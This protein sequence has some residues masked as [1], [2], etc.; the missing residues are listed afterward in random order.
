M[1][2]LRGH[3]TGADCSERFCPKGTAWADAAISEDTAHQEAECSGRGICDRSSGSCSCDAGFGGNACQ[4]MECPGNCFGQGKCSTMHELASTGRRASDSA[5]FAYAAAWDAHLVRGCVCEP[6]FSGHDC[7]LR[8]CPAGD[9]P[10]T[11]GQVNEVQYLTCS[12]TSGS[13]ALFFGGVATRAVRAAATASEVAAALEA[14]PLIGR[15][16]VSF[17]PSAGGAP[18]YPRAPLLPP[19]AAAARGRL[20]PQP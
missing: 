16:H 2:V 9:D 20:P 17:H 10:L 3:F 1:H 6:G 8:D 5:S 12:A 15:V 13:L 14:H 7:R 18:L 4:R 11:A 19:A